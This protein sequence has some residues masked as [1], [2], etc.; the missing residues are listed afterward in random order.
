MSG[1]ASITPLAPARENSRRWRWG[2][3]LTKLICNGP[4]ADKLA[5]GVSSESCA[6]SDCLL[7]ENISELDHLPSYLSSSTGQSNG[8]C[9]SHLGLSSGRE[10]HLHV[11]GSGPALAAHSVTR[12]PHPQL[13]WPQSAGQ[14]AQRCSFPASTSQ[15]L[16]NSS[17]TPTSFDTLVGP[18]FYRGQQ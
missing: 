3:V 15:Q 5:I 2:R 6:C 14:P 13:A 8:F 12:K 1:E 10:P 18:V 9:S 17:P 7:D 11:P 16:F 4:I